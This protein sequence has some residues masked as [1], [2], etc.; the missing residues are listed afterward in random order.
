MGLTYQKN[1][2]IEEAIKNY[3]EAAQIAGAGDYDDIKANAYQYLGNIYTETSQ[4]MKAIECYQKARKVDACHKRDKW[5]LTAYLRLRYNHLEARQHMECIKY[6][7]EAV[8][9]ASYFTDQK[10]RAV[11]WYKKALNLTKFSDH[12]ELLQEKTLTGLGLAWENR[13]DI[14]NAT[15]SIQEAGKFVKK[16]TDAS[17]YFR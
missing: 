10:N 6:Y 11:E 15:E 3:K 13:G 17:N 14:E 4:H 9:L 7:K 16:E 1:G 5:E 12:V 8:I 2:K